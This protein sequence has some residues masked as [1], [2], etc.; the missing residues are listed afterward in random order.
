MYNLE[1]IFRELIIN[2]KSIDIADSEFKKMIA[3]DNELRQLYKD[4]CHEVGSTERLGFRD[5]CNEYIENQESVWESLTDYDE[6][7]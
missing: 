5:F 3:E 4:W 6:E 7:Q 2:H 1:D